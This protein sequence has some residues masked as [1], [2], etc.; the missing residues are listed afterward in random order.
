MR[1]GNLIVGTEFVEVRTIQSGD[2]GSLLHV[3]TTLLEAFAQVDRMGLRHR[4]R[5]GSRSVH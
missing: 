3:A 4:F 2:P 1:Y 5:V